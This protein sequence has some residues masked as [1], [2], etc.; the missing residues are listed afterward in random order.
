M[1]LFTPLP[2]NQL[3]Q[4]TKEFNK[5]DS[6]IYAEA[7]FTCAF[8]ARGRVVRISGGINSFSILNYAQTTYSERNGFPVR[9]NGFA[10]E[11]LSVHRE[12]L[13]DENVVMIRE[14]DEFGGLSN[15]WYHFNN[16]QVFHLEMLYQEATRR[17]KEW[18]REVLCSFK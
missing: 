18:K 13:R 4:T 3:Q 17:L 8:D 6:R 12:T 14:Y 15:V 2:G 9:Y 10:V 16:H 1:R 11:R 5:K 7:N